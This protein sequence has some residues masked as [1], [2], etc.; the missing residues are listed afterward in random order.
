MLGK[1]NLPQVDT[2]QIAGHLGAVPDARY[3][4][5]VEFHSGSRLN[6][7]RTYE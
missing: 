1:R 6:S 3:Q 7:F 4:E 2:H 5:P